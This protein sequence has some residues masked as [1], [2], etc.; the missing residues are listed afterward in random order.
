MLRALCLTLLASAALGLRKFKRSGSSTNS[1]SGEVLTELIDIPG[2]ACNGRASF[3][4]RVFWPA[5]GKDLPVLAFA[6]GGRAA[7]AAQGKGDGQD[8][9]AQYTQ[10]LEPI[11]RAGY[12]VIAFADCADSFKG[13]EYEL[14]D[15]IHFLRRRAGY[16]IDF[17]APATIAGHGGGGWATL[18]AA[19]DG[20]EVWGANIGLA[21]SLHPGY[22]GKQ[23]PQVSTVYWTGELDEQNS[24][25]SVRSMYND[26]PPNIEKV[27]AV[28]GKKAYDAPQNDPAV[29][30]KW[31][32]QFMDCKIRGIQQACGTRGGMCSS[33]DFT[34]DC[35]V[36]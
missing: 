16:P 24:A 10:L 31:M 30:V 7:L 11:A 35:E 19:S 14:L 3:K 32:V 17:R 15:S 28:F 13:G 8:Y 4:A 22:Y 27:F 36:A 1:T 18:A 25:R 33:G 2:R 9:A 23:A 34:Q 12:L 6:H 5:T 20:K 29:Y 21:L 26:A